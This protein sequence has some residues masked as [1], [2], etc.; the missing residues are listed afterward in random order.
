[1]TYEDAPQTSL[2]SSVGHED[3]EALVRDT[4]ARAESWKN[5]AL[6]GVQVA[7]RSE[8]RRVLATVF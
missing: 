7:Q 6:L 2:I 3:S 8:F 4:A 1:M 5:E